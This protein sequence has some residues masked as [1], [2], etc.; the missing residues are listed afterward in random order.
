MPGSLRKIL[1]LLNNFQNLSKSTHEDKN[2]I[3]I[4][5]LVLQCKV[6]S[7]TAKTTQHT[8]IDFTHKL[9]DV[10]QEISRHLSR[11]KHEF[12]VNKSMAIVFGLF[13]SEKKQNKDLSKEW[14]R[15]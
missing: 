9:S 14:I 3:V 15:C 8:R 11:S 2:I 10:R 4:T 7:H 6:S 1:K 5:G 12:R 13:L